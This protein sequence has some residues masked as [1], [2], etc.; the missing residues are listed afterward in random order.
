[1]AKA[2]KKT[3][4][5]TNAKLGAM[6]KKITSEAKR[7]RSKS[8]GKKWITCMKEAGKKMKKKK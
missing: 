1:M 7:I 4:K 5:M 2:K 8:P 3:K 6:G